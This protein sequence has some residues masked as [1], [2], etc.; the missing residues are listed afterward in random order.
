[1]QP[2][3]SSASANDQRA[4]ACLAARRLTA[5]KVVHVHVRFSALLHRLFGAEAESSRDNIGN[6]CETLTEL[7]DEA[8]RELAVPHGG[9]DKEKPGRLGAFVLLGEAGR[10]MAATPFTA[11]VALRLPPLKKVPH[12]GRRRHAPREAGAEQWGLRSAQCELGPLCAVACCRGRPGRVE[13]G[14]ELAAWVLDGWPPPCAHEIS[15]GFVGGLH[16]DDAKR[17]EQARRHGRRARST[18]PL[19]GVGRELSRGVRSHDVPVRRRGDDSAALAARGEVRRSIHSTLIPTN[20]NKI[21]AGKLTPALHARIVQA[22]LGAR[23]RRRGSGGR[24]GSDGSRVLELP[25]S[26][27]HEATLEQHGCGGGSAIAAESPSPST[28]SNGDSL[29][30]EPPLRA[31]GPHR[32]DLG[33]QPNTKTRRLGQVAEV[34]CILRAGGVLGVQR[35]CG[36]GPKGHRV[37][38]ER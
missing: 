22:K 30:L 19:G 38:I 35:K 26:P 24:I 8:K 21:V 14:A 20:H 33:V 5:F 2:R 15:T 25:S 4:S 3:T 36:G 23:E 16:R 9:A 18:H 31:A 10:S 28:S 6:D 1:M 12:D 13:G 37:Q 29:D 11:T 7:V 32:E 34:G 27:N 17:R